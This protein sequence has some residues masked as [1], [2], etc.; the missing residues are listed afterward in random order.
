MLPSAETLKQFLISVVLPP[1][2]GIVTTFVISN[3]HVLNV[4]HISESA[5]A[6]ELTQ[7]GTFAITTLIAAVF[8]HHMNKGTFTPAARVAQGKK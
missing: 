8:G 4:F 5:I 6:G 3:V 1:L 2:V 7:L